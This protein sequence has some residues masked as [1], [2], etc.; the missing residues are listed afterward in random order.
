M[1]VECIELPGQQKMGA[2]DIEII[3]IRMLLVVQYLY[4][5]LELYYKVF[6]WQYVPFQLPEFKKGKMAESQFQH[7]SAAAT[8]TT[9]SPLSKTWRKSFVKL[10]F[11]QCW[12]IT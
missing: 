4:F 9:C 10:T 2:E 8:I 1:K 7:G 3:I 12:R 5:S 11:H 6:I